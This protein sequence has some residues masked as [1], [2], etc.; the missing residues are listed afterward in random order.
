MLGL[1]WWRRKRF[2]MLIESSQR[3]CRSRAR[4]CVPDV[5]D[6]HETSTGSLAT[7]FRSDWFEGHR[8]RATAEASACT[9]MAAIWLQ[10]DD[11]IE[12]LL[13]A[14]VAEGDTRHKL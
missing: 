2:H 11:C 9:A 10:L 7:L 13:G 3:L 1:P 6:V 5:A 12:R 8:L 14:I 4:R